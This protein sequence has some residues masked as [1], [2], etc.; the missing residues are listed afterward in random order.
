MNVVSVEP[1]G[2]ILNDASAQG[3]QHFESNTQMNYGGASSNNTGGVRVKG[4]SVDWD[5][6]GE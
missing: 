3:V 5:D 2:H 1:H 6:W 4:N